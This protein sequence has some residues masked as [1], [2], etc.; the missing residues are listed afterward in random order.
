MLL[1]TEG[2]TDCSRDWFI[3]LTMDEPL[4]FA[5][6]RL[7]LSIATPKLDCKFARDMADDN[8]GIFM[9]FPSF[10]ENEE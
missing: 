6:S 9:P 8:C 1:P 5:L 4:L 2:L 10:H 7:L 3:I